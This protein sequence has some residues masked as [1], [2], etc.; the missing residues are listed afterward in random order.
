MNLYNSLFMFLL[1]LCP[2]TPLSAQTGKTAEVETWTLIDNYFFV[3]ILK[4]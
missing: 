4:V 3:R 2:G 1:F